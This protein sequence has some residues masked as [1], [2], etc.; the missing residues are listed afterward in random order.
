[1]HFEESALVFGDIVL[2]PFSFTDQTTTKKGPAV[3]I[4]AAAYR[5]DIILMAVTSQLR[6]MA[7]LG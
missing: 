2:V 1:M 4:S 6:A 7:V 5:P 3:V